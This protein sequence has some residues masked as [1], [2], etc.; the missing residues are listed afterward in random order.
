MAPPTH[1][2]CFSRAKLNRLDP[3][4]E[5]QARKDGGKEYLN[6]VVVGRFLNYF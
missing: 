6:L 5:F 1:Y 2:K 3:A 4:K